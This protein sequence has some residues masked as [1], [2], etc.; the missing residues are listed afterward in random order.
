MR[1]LLVV[2]SGPSGVGKGTIAKRIVKSQT[3]GLPVSMY[4]PRCKSTKEYRS[5]TDEILNKSFTKKISTVSTIKSKKNSEV[6]KI[7]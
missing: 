4:D 1:N 6:A 2:L 5:V 3:N 7:C